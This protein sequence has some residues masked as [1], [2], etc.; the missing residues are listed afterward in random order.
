MTKQEQEFVGVFRQKLAFP[1]E[2]KPAEDLLHDGVLLEE[3]SAVNEKTRVTTTSLLLIVEL[4]SIKK[5]EIEESDSDEEKDLV[6]PASVPF[7]SPTKLWGAPDSDV[8]QLAK[9]MEAL[10][11]SGISLEA[12]LKTSTS[13]H[14]TAG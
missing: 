14:A 9:V 3:F 4:R 10:N 6:G 5:A 1:V 11:D 12:F 13:K 2:D 7:T 8:S